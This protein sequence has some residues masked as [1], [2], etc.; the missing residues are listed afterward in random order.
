MH[1]FEINPIR[2]SCIG[3]KSLK[4]VETPFKT[5]L[6][7]FILLLPGRERRKLQTSQFCFL[8]PRTYFIWQADALL[9]LTVYIH[10]LICLFHIA[11]DILSFYFET[12]LETLAN[13]L[14][15]FFRPMK[16]DFDLVF[17]FFWFSPDCVA[18]EVSLLWSHVGFKERTQKG[19]TLFLLLL[20]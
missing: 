6:F 12:E 5:E 17:S 19:E 20:P 16:G 7:S 13:F 14:K 1:F 3:R 8:G 9:I 2:I 18:D 15:F 4:I 10:R 11:L